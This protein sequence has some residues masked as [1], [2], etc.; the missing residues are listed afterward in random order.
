ML[1]LRDF[2]VRYAGSPTLRAVSLR[3]APG[4]LAWVLGRNGSVAKALRTHRR[5]VG[6]LPFSGNQPLAVSHRRRSAREEKR[7]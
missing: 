7:E 1:E 5:V 2:G 6:V 4:E 3:L